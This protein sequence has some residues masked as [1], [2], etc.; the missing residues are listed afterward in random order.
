MNRRIVI[1]DAVAPT[2]Y[3]VILAVAGWLLLR[4]HN[5]PG[6]GFI[7]SLVALSATVL[8][9]V[10][11]DPAAAARRLPTGSPVRLAAVGVLLAGLS[12]LPGLAGG[13]SYLTHLWWTLDLGVTSMKLSTVLV[14]DIGVTLGVWGAL[15]GYALG[16]LA[17]DP[18]AGE[19]EP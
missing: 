18:A 2:L 19:S 11:R 12:G 10:A 13:G 17:V 3:W 6:G 15:A 7:A 8:W 16:L 5:E 1:L 14:F 4:G 9:A